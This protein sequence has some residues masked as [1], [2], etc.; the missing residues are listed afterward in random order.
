MSP[1]QTWFLV[2]LLWRPVVNNALVEK[3][4]IN[5]KNVHHDKTGD[6]GLDNK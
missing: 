4:L 3:K 6:T 2:Y 5:D 1:L